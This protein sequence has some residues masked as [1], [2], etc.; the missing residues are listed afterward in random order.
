MSQQD[1]TMQYLTTIF[2]DL[3][4]EWIEQ[5]ILQ[6]PTQRI[7]FLTEQCVERC[8]QI[9]NQKNK[10]KNHDA[11]HAL[12]A[13]SLNDE[14]SSNQENITVDCD[15]I[16]SSLLSIEM[17]VSF[18]K[19][20]FSQFESFC[21]SIN[22]WK[23]S[24]KE[25]F[26]DYIMKPS[27]EFALKRSVEIFTRFQM[28]TFYYSSNFNQNKSNVSI[29]S[30]QKD[31]YSINN[32]INIFSFMKRIEY[33]TLDLLGLCELEYQFQLLITMALQQFAFV[34]LCQVEYGP[35]KRTNGTN[36][37]RIDIYYEDFAN[38]SYVVELK[39]IKLNDVCYYC[40]NYNMLSLKGQKKYEYK[41]MKV[42]QILIDAFWQSKSYQKYNRNGF[43]AIVLIGNEMKSIGVVDKILYINN[44][45]FD[46]ND[47]KI[48]M[49]KK[50]LKECFG[51]QWHMYY[52]EFFVATWFYW[53][54]VL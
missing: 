21:H 37:G 6:F 44:E 45:K 12:S 23:Y 9:N 40:N 8:Q 20:L 13:L 2:E 47:V 14:E 3:D 5:L 50:W 17:S 36:Y 46:P 25:P 18:G 51:G 52:I 54:N 11:T 15:D 33:Y 32:K 16:T 7:E 31:K 26:W 42:D 22:G 34:K 30:V 29:N 19:H 24:T 43:G 4:K 53:I 27:N 1:G 35:V 10:N 41:F 39:L 49:I 48:D 38:Y 28:K